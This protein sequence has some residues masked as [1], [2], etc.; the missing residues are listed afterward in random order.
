MV[1][2][3]FLLRPSSAEVRA[4][5]LLG[6]GVYRFSKASEAIH[7]RSGENLATDFICVPV[8]SRGD[9]VEQRA[10]SP[11]IVQFPPPAVAALKAFDGTVVGR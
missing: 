2:G 8:R 9:C 4:E 11:R 5:G 6:G 10:V 1:A 7:H 3:G